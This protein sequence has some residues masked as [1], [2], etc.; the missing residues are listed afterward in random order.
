[1]TRTDF[2]E[3][4]SWLRT[5]YSLAR[6]AEKAGNSFSSAVFR[7]SRQFRARS[8]PRL[9]VTVCA[10]FGLRLLSEKF[11]SNAVALFRSADSLEQKTSQADGLPTVANSSTQLNHLHDQIRRVIEWAE[12]EDEE[13]SVDTGVAADAVQLL[14]RT[15]SV[16]RDRGEGELFE[17]LPPGIREAHR[18]ALETLIQDCVVLQSWVDATC[19]L[20]DALSQLFGAISKLEASIRGVR[21]CAAIQSRSGLTTNKRL[22]DDLRGYS[23]PLESVHRNFMD[24]AKC[25]AI[26][27]L[28]AEYHLDAYRCLDLDYVRGRLFRVEGYFTDRT[29]DSLL[30]DVSRDLAHL[31]FDV[32]SDPR[33]VV[34]IYSLNAL[35][36]QNM[37]AVA[38]SNGSTEFVELACHLESK[39]LRISRQL[40]AMLG[41]RQKQLKDTAATLE[42]LLLDARKLIA[43][44]LILAGV[45]RPFGTL[46]V[47]AC[48]TAE[49]FTN[50]LELSPSSSN[51]APRTISTPEEMRSRIG[52]F[53]ETLQCILPAASSDESTLQRHSDELETLLKHLRDWCGNE[54]FTQQE[55]RDT[56]GRAATRVWDMSA[57]SGED[58][59][60]HVVVALFLLSRTTTAPNR[61]SCQREKP[62]WLTQQA[63]WE[64]MNQLVEYEPSALP[65]HL[66]ATLSL[67]SFQ[68]Q[69]SVDWVRCSVKQLAIDALATALSQNDEIRKRSATFAQ[70]FAEKFMVARDLLQLPDSSVTLTLVQPK[71][72]RNLSFTVP[73]QIEKWPAWL[74]THVCNFVRKSIVAFVLNSIECDTRMREIVAGLCQLGIVAE[75]VRDEYELTEQQSEML[76]DAVCDA[77]GFMCHR[78]TDSKTIRGLG[79]TIARLWHAASDR[80]KEATGK[81]SATG[82]GHGI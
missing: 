60:R 8:L 38:S 43:R 24:A 68:L 76:D 4:V 78:R 23:R 70:S 9:D 59:I 65:K 13:V 34:D 1:M 47:L 62:E 41:R 33:D 3:C 19:K 39:A 71:G 69:T 37:T 80:R 45:E 49:T 81:V 51:A 56:A 35:F 28:D 64:I 10:Q 25:R 58:D 75:M 26:F 31:R 48:D 5:H 16:A 66:A 61:A 32:D 6:D 15:R 82:M 67:S 18:G 14:N 20:S 27:R 57:A 50:V 17:D 46:K 12:A 77:L 30:T 52:S 72:S 40:N 73:W 53:L 42:E 11:E 54:D 36:D 44:H 7:R 21:D 79:I 55:A 63:M 2:Q 22:L 74:K 29:L